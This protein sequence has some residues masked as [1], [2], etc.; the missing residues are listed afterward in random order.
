VPF[1]VDKI[2]QR[3]RAGRDP[4]SGAEEHSPVIFDQKS[5]F[6]TPLLPPPLHPSRERA[7][8][9]NLLCVSAIIQNKNFAKLKLGIYYFRKSVSRFSENN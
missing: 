5:N 9:P 1:L 6:F 4:A 3:Q 7:G 2:L 8:F